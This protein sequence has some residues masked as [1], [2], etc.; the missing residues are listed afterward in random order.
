MSWKIPLFKI[1]WDEGDVRVVSDAIKKGMN[2]ATGPDVEKFEELI[3]SYVGTE[4]A[5][6]FNSGTSALH[7]AMIAYKIK[8]GDE[9][10]VPSFTFIA[11]ANAPLFV[12][13]KPVFADIEEETFGLDPKDVKEK[14]TSKTKAIIPIHYG[15]C[16][17]KIR[18]LKEIAE[19]HNLI[20][21]EDAAESL[22]TAIKDK[23]VGTFGDSTMFSLCAPK[24]ITTGE[25][26][27]IVTDSTEVYEKLKL[28]RSHGRAET[29]DYFS[30]TEYMDYIALGYN[31]RMSNL[32]AALGIAQLKKIEEII[33]MR[34]EKAEYM[35]KKLSKIEDIKLPYAPKDYFHVYQMFTIRMSEIKRMRKGLKN[36]LAGKGIMSKVY[37]E[38]V[39]LTT[40]YKKVLGYDCNLPVT[41]KISREVL[42]LPMY[43]TLTKNE[44]DYITDTIIEFFSGDLN[45]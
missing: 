14:I 7:A 28:I 31:F 26:G 5:I 27:I 34:R 29:E 33:E 23:K 44:I 4:Y 16:P 11:T 22:G 45:G 30:S 15:G 12:G 38:P 24:V 13:A 43:P 37:F 32:T 9:V 40:F 39:H 20:L 3:A 10:I 18:E 25:G 2:W 19:D 17:C 42:T 6:T 8:Q 41:E 21:I 36:Y 1:Y 35:I